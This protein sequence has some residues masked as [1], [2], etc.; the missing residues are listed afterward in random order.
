MWF[1]ELHA[2]RKVYSSHITRAFRR[3]PC[4]SPNCRQ[5]GVDP[6]TRRPLR[7]QFA[8]RPARDPKE[9][10]FRR[11]AAGSAGRLSAIGSPGFVR[12]V[13]SGSTAR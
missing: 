2:R 12:P 1:A 4:T 5:A 9:D 7:M 13:R 8:W 11:R 3:R 6:D 10:N